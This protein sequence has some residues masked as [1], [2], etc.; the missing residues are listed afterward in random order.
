MDAKLIEARCVRCGGGLVGLDTLAARLDGCQGICGDCRAG[1]GKDWAFRAARPWRPENFRKT[2]TGSPGE[3]G[4]FD[5]Q[6]D[7]QPEG[8]S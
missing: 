4:L 2:S 7:E 8:R 5:K 3:M 6:L 1:G